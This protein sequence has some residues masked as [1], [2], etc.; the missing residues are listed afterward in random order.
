[1]R[2]LK[3]LFETKIS[4]YWTQQCLLIYCLCLGIKNKIE[5]VIKL[6]NR[7]FKAPV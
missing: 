2:E 4:K 5:I 1:M 3:N 6:K 7:F